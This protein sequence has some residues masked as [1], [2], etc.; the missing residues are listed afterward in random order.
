MNI[1]ENSITKSI[2]MWRLPLLLVRQFHL[3]F[4]QV[5]NYR[6]T[7]NDDK[8]NWLRFNLLAK[9]LYELSDA[10]TGNDPVE[11]LD[12][13]C[14]LQYVLDGAFLSLGYGDARNLA[15]LEV[16]RSNMSKLGADGKPV[17]REDKKVLKGPSYTPPD[18][19][20]VLKEVYGDES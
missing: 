15:F 6:P 5:I 4:G 13:L 9:E 19:A 2:P 3:V 17:Y 18:L 20:G 10:F 1:Y 12:A 16:H 8:L 14:D 11:V 7:V